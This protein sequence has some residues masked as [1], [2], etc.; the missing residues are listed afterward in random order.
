MNE[1]F[2]TRTAIERSLRSLR[3]LP[4][5][6][7]AL[8][9][10]ACADHVVVGDAKPDPEQPAKEQA[11]EEVDNPVDDGV[12]QQVDD[13]VD[14]PVVP[15]G[16]AGSSGTTELDCSEKD[17]GWRAPYDAWKE[18]E[19]DFGV[20]A[21]KTLTGYIEGGP[22]LLLTI[23][24]DHTATLVVGEAAAPP[25]KDQSYLCDNEFEDEY[26]AC[27][28]AYSSPPVPGGTYPLHGATLEN[29][30]L[31]LPIQQLVP[32]DA[33]C[34]LQDPK[35]Q[36]PCFFSTVTNEGFSWSL[37]ACSLGEAS[38][39]CGWL[40]LAQSG[41]CSCTSTECFALIAGDGDLLDARLNETE[42]ELVGSFKG[43]TVYLFAAEE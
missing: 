43:A 30:R 22:D 4:L 18:I 33:W 38:V 31:K 8:T 9:A 25:E 42:N 5:A 7:V 28:V 20:L 12:D 3:W 35:Q 32:W 15:A 16:E 24:A 6:G 23:A 17:A 40:K 11:E 2:T 26:V 21:G 13:G 39:D 10:L 36:E 14:E 1:P 29:S 37:D 41:I 19:N 27:E 34:A